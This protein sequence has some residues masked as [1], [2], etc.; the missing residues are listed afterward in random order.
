MLFREITAVFAF[1]TK[2]TNFTRFYNGRTQG[3]FANKKGKIAFPPNL[4]FFLFDFFQNY[5]VGGTKNKVV[6]LAAQN[7]L[8]IHVFQHARCATFIFFCHR[9]KSYFKITRFKVMIIINPSAFVFIR[10][11]VIFMIYINVFKIIVIK[12]MFKFIINAIQSC[13]NVR[14]KHP[15]KWA[16]EIT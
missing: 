13:N 8:H 12:I 14:P 15:I 4:P 3:R 2:K 7:P 1:I 9:R 11:F 10:P 16:T 5:F 6:R